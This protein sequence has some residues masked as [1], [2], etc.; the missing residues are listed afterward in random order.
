MPGTYQGETLP[1]QDTYNEDDML[2]R[3]QSIPGLD[4]SQA[5]FMP[6]RCRGDVLA[7]LSPG[8]WVWAESHPSALAW[9]RPGISIPQ[10][11]LSTRAH[12]K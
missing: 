9:C 6:L 12:P 8:T 4:E 3:R 2:T 11:L 1:H 5:A 7:Q 10:R